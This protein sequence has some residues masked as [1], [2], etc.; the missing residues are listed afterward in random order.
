MTCSDYYLTNYDLHSNLVPKKVERIV[1]V[2]E[3]NAI[4]SLDNDTRI[5]APHF[6]RYS[7]QQYGFYLLFESTEVL[8]EPIAVYKSVSGWRTSNGAATS[9]IA[10]LQILFHI[11]HQLSKA[12]HQALPHLRSVTRARMQRQSSAVWPADSPLQ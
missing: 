6:T 11:L 5:V 8:R 7:S 1:N 2:N 3:L 12:V 10:S 4:N 9:P